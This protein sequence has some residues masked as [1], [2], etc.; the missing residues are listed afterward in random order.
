MRRA[1]PFLALAGCAP[2]HTDDWASALVADGPCYR[3]NL[4]DGLEEETHTELRDL[5][6]CVNR[7]GD[8][9][10]LAPVVDGLEARSTTGDPAWRQAAEMVNRLPDAG[11]APFAL[12]GVLLDALRAPERPV[13]VVLDLVLELIY[14][15]PAVDSRA[16]PGG[17]SAAD[18]LLAP[19]APLVPRIATELLRD[20]RALA[21]W[22]GDLLADPDTA[23]W[24]R[25]IGGFAASTDPTVVGPVADLPAAL[26]G[27]RNATLDGENDR[28]TGASGD[29]LRDAFDAWV[30]A[31]EPVVPAIADETSLILADVKIRTRL[32]SELVRLGGDGTLGRAA[33][34]AGWMSSVDPHGGVLGN[35]EDSALHAFVRLLANTNQPMDCSIDLGLFDLD[36]SFGNLAVSTL[37]L[38]ADVDPESLQ[39]AG[40][41]YGL[42]FGNDIG[43]F[44]LD[45]A[46][47]L[48]VCPGLTTQVVDDLSAV[49][50][51]AEPQAADLLTAFVAVL[52]TLEEGDENRIPAL[53]DLA[54]DLNA[55]GGWPA[56]EELLRDAATSTAIDDAVLLL[57]AL[58]DPAGADI[59]ASTDPAVDLQELLDLV[60][61]AVDVD[62][63]TGETGF[64][65]VSP[66]VSTVGGDDA[67]WLVIDHGIGL[68]ADPR[69]RLGSG[70]ALVTGL[71]AADPD[72]VLL[73]TL[74]RL[75]GDPALAE[76]AL[77]LIETPGVADAALAG[78]PAEGQ[79]ETPLGFG[80]RLITD[81]TFADLLQVLDLAL[82]LLGGS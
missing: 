52:D 47:D 68:V 82:A 63:A 7:T 44:V 51:L 21:S 58:A 53:A 72:L 81:G 56:T 37:E 18:G 65:R 79:D 22:A 27:L 39:T 43:E 50:V 71:L 77:R 23:R 30:T 61:W 17:G 70:P 48:G 28:W 14:G 33:D 11:I 15:V 38:I 67:T 6:A 55:T 62:P 35:G 45:E 9:D 80:G 16:D 1:L 46:A 24:I 3:V 26:G 75:V 74:G 25:T 57:P 49:E 36:F 19:L 4:L 60:G 54:D 29:S 13:D 12:A 59:S 10:A 78:A 42:L 34:G 41:I 20:D 66:L 73:D 40:S 5:Y 32:Q 31:P 76:P 64:D 69:A 2:P 8:F